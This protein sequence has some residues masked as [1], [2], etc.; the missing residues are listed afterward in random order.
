MSAIPKDIESHWAAIQPFLTIHNEEEYDQAIERLN[1]LLDEVGTDHS[2]PLYELLDTLGALIQVYEEKHHTVPDRTGVDML[3]YLMT[4]HG[5]SI[6][7]LNDLGGNTD[8]DGILQG[9][10]DLQLSQ[11]RLLS[12]RFGV[13]PAVFV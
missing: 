12:K 13:S 7:D 6:A 11:I 4:E 3:R 8:F 5:L 9:K 10:R 1:T 2:H